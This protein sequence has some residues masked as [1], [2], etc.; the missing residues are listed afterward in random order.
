MRAWLMV[1]RLPGSNMRHFSRKSFSWWTF[2]RWASSRVCVPTRDTRRSRGG[3]ELITVTFSC[4]AIEKYFSITSLSLSLSLTYP[5]GD[6]IHL[7][8][9]EVEGRIKMVVFEHSLASHLVRHLP[10][11]LHHQLQHLIVGLPGKENLSS[12]EFINGAPHSPHVQA[13]LILVAND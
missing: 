8:V 6:F 10:L 5:L 4:V 1:M 2:R 11:H 13:I 12:V 7:C 9:E 3:K